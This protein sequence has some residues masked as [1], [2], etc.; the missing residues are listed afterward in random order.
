MANESSIAVIHFADPW[1]WWSWGLEPVVQRLKEVYGDQV[2]IVYKMGG[3]TDSTANWRKEYN[4]EE[5]DALRSWIRDSGSI[6]GMNVDPESYLKSGVQSTW[7]ACVAVKAAQLQGE[8]IGERFYRKLMEA[9]LLESR[10]GSHETT[11]LSLAKQVGLDEAQLKRDISSGKARELFEKDKKE[12]NVNFLTLTYI[13]RKTGKTRN[14]EGV[15]TSAEHQKAVEELSSAEP[16]RKTPVDILEYLD[17]H[18]DTLVYPKEIAE[19]FSTSLQDAESRLEGLAKSGLLSRNELGFG[20]FFQSIPEAAKQA[21]LTIQ[22]VKLSHVAGPTQVVAESNLS[23]VIASAVKGLYTQVATNPNKAYHFPLGR[24]ALLYVGYPESELNRLPET[25]LESFAG[26]GYPHLSGAIK[27]GDTVVD[28]G[29]GSGTDVLFASLLTGPT[30]KVLGLDIT[31]AMIQKARDNIAKM[32]VK[33]VKI[34]EGDATKIPL[35]DDSVD[36]VTS[37][38]VLNL[39]PE[40]TK[41]FQEIHRVLKPGGRLQLADIVVQSN[42]QKV[43]GLIPQLW[44][45]CIGGAA[46]ES[47]YL[48][49]INESGF[50]D[51]KIINRLDYFAASSSE[52]TKRLTKVFQA[53]TVVITA[54]KPQ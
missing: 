6:T 16:T 18:H 52:N 20:T 41:A 36:V 24:K 8:E 21:Q 27:T 29:S 39:V 28:I 48:K 51:T 53:E 30:G 43:C 40:K 17:R 9:N 7:P 5:D 50:K 19:I 44:A 47:E 37:N 4:V 11:Y 22:Q 23:E 1:C 45:D 25:A 10:N 54:T 46:V 38:G 2:E 3:I 12:M 33:N 14:I 42:V 15:F 34:I 32:G 35:E 26:V 49:T 31:E 13:N